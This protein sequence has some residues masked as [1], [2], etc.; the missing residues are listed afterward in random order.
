MENQIKFEVIVWNQASRKRDAGLSAT[1]N[2]DDE[3]V[4]ME[5][6]SS[7]LELLL[8]IREQSEQLYG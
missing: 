8:A 7:K 6:I 2:A 4:R 5:R 3:G 1:R